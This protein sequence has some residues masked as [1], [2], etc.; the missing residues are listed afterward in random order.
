MSVARIRYPRQSQNRAVAAA[1]IAAQWPVGRSVGP[2][3]GRPGS[4]RR[5]TGDRGAVWTGLG[6]MCLSAENRSVRHC[7]YLAWHIWVEL[8][9]GW[10]ARANFLTITP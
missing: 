6:V 4:R 8:R 3:I 9:R 7:R 1:S 5:G 10:L 2:L